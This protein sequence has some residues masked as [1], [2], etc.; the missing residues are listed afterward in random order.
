MKIGIVAKEYPPMRGGIGTLTEDLARFASRKWPVMVFL[1]GPAQATIE[2][3]EDIEV[4]P[5][6]DQATPLLVFQTLKQHG[7]THVLFNHRL[8]ASVSLVCRC[9]L[10]GIRMWIYVHGADVNLGSY[11]HLGLKDRLRRRLIFGLQQGVVVNSR[12]TRK[13]LIRRFWRGK[14][15]ILHPGIALSAE[16]PPKRAGLKTGDVVAL[17]RLVR[18]KGFDVL[19]ETIRR[20]GDEV[21]LTIIGNGPDRDFLKAETERLGMPGRV[22]FLQGLSNEEV[23]EEL[24]AHKVFC[25]LPRVLL[26][27]DVEGFGIVFLE[28]A[29]LGLPVVAGNSGGVPDAVNDGVNGFLVDPENPDEIAD[30]LN[31]LFQDDKLYEKMSRASLEWAKKFDWNRRNPEEEFRFLLK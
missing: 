1:T 7:I 12:S 23:H 22:R 16:S 31:L 4:V 20:M 3:S 10:V 25:L 15:N 19:L 28:A 21:S 29:S 30:K 27:G 11:A 5:L 2:Y 13:I 24:C 8:S 9:W 26:D 18:R 14:T 6:G 17:G